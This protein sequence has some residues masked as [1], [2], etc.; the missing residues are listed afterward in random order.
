M[1]SPLDLDQLQSF[2]AIADCG[3]FTEAA[4]RV[5]KTQSAVSMQIKRLEERLGQALL[6]RDGR[7]VALTEYGDALYARARRMLRIN[8]EIFEASGVVVEKRLEGDAASSRSPGF[9]EPVHQCAQR[10][11]RCGSH[12]RPLARK[13]V[14]HGPSPISSLPGQGVPGRTSDPRDRRWVLI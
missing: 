3:S 13:Q 11:G 10:V 1:T 2:C 4:R 7:T 12:R 8:A 14:D 6:S 9:G 5:N